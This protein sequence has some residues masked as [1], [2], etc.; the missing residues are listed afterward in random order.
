[1]CKVYALDELNGLFFRFL[2]KGIFLFYDN[3]YFK[4]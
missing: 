3:N 1:M 4:K 2:T